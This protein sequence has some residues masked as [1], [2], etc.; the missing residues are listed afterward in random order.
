MEELDHLAGFKAK[1]RQAKSGFYLEG[2]NGEIASLGGSGY[3]ALLSPRDQE[4]ICENLGLD[5]TLLG[6]DPRSS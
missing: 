6:L 3:G 5:A 4:T 1:L 2:P